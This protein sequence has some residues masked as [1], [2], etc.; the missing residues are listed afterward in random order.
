MRIDELSDL[1]SKRAGGRIYHAV[2]LRDLRTYV[3][4]GHVASRAELFAR[5]PEA[6]TPFD[7]D[8]DDAQVMNCETDVFGNLLDQ[9]Q[10]M[11]SGRGI[12][13]AYGPITL[14]F[15][16]DSLLRSGAREVH[17][18][19]NAIWRAKDEGSRVLDDPRDIEA[20]YDVK[21]WARAGEVQIVGG[22]L[23]LADVMYVLVN[24]I[25][26]NG[27]SL[28]TEV[29]ACL[30]GVVNNRGLPIAVRE[31]DLEGKAGGPMYEKLVAWAAAA[32][33]NG[34]EVATLP[35][36]VAPWFVSIAVPKKD[37]QIKRFANYL[38]HGTISALD[39][40]PGH[41]QA[42]VALVEDE[43]AEDDWDIYFHNWDAERFRLSD[44]EI[45]DRDIAL[46]SVERA[47]FR[48]RQALYHGGSVGAPDVAVDASWQEFLEAL[49]DLNYWIETTRAGILATRD[50]FHTSSPDAHDSEASVGMTAW[51]DEYDAIEVPWDADPDSIDLD[52][53]RWRDV[54]D[55]GI[56][57]PHL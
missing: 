37:A 4:L 14:V 26:V 10:F 38:A 11:G 30:A 8:V 16:H 7:S 5:G 39:G 31:R 21:G 42:R 57:S 45:A 28:I 18:R 15:P 17:V 47:E 52:D 29:T 56:Q 9:G 46:A 44:E 3:A 53:I 36:D 27:L 12:P 49:S 32:P 54:R 35:P 34:G 23:F 22:T 25:L 41:L 55:Y 51:A 20:L 1:L 6:Y 33:R 40:G 48:L 2:Q 43:C 24:P 13:N 50:E 19:R